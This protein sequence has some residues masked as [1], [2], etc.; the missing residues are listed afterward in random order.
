M[1]LLVSLLK[2]THLGPPANNH[3]EGSRFRFTKAMHANHRDYQE[4][5]VAY[6]LQNM[7]RTFEEGQQGENTPNKT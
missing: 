3:G 4:A 6:P 2:S 1:C 7:S 5:K